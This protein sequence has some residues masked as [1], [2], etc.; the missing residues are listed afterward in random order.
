MSEILDFFADNPEVAGSIAK[1]VPAIMGI[2]QANKAKNAIEGPGGYQEKLENLE[3]E[4]WML[5]EKNLQVED[6]L[7]HPLQC[8][9]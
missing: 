2:H 6:L 8:L 5:E 3:V 7:N 9:Q 1:T 4:E